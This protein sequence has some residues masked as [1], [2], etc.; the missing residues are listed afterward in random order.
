MLTEIGARLQVAMMCSMPL[1][2]KQDHESPP[3]GKPVPRRLS[4]KDRA[5][6]LFFANPAWWNAF[7]AVQVRRA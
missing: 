1:F 6:S 3:R 5:R 4:R 2:G 7:I